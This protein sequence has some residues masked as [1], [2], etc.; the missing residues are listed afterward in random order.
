MESLGHF[1]F[2]LIKITI[3]GF[4]YS[5]I[6]FFLYNRIPENT[7]PEWCKK[8]LKSK[9]TLWFGISLFL[10]FYMFTPYGNHGLGDSARIP[11]NFTKE[12]SNTNWTEFGR[13]NGIKTSCDND[14]ELTHFIIK[15]NKLY[16]NL[17]SD[18]YDYNNSYFI[19]DLKS[20]KL[21][22]FENEFSY[23]EYTRLNSLPKSYE[24]KNF[25]ENYKSYWSGWRFFLLP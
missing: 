15:N 10:L 18:F 16:G 3:L 1:I 19:Y 23:N 6:L 12:I 14:V 11:L 22:E 17:K 4:F 7:K 25:S 2:E 21:Q 5:W 24:L 9:K 20:E 13:L 8:V